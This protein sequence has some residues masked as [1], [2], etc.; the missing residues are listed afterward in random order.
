MEAI[1]TDIFDWKAVDDMRLLMITWGALISGITL[2]IYIPLIYQ[3]LRAKDAG[4]RAANRKAQL[5]VILLLAGPVMTISFLSQLWFPDIEMLV[6]F[7]SFSYRAFAM[8]G[9]WKYALL[10]F[11]EKMSILVRDGEA[12]Y[13]GTLQQYSP[14]KIW[15]QLPC[16]C[17]WIFRAPWMKPTI[18]SVSDFTSLHW[19]VIQL[20]AVAPFIGAIRLVFLQFDL[21]ELDVVDRVANGILIGSVLSASYAINVICCVGER[22][23]PIQYQLQRRDWFKFGHKKMHNELLEE[24][25]QIEPLK[26]KRNYIIFCC[27][28]PIVCRF[29]AI[30]LDGAPRFGVPCL[31]CVW[32]YHK[33]T[34]KQDGSNICY[35]NG[36]GIGSRDFEVMVH[37]CM[38][39]N[40]EL[41][42]AIFAKYVAF[43][44]K[45]NNP[46]VEQIERMTATYLEMEEWPQYM[47][48]PL[49][50]NLKS[51]IEI[52]EDRLKENNDALFGQEPSP[53]WKEVFG[54]GESA[55]RKAREADW[56]GGKPGGASRLIV[57]RP[58]LMGMMKMGAV[59]SGDWNSS[60]KISQRQSAKASC[61]E[62][63]DV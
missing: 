55:E 18:I 51:L 5:Q 40:W 4:G 58:S 10:Q 61:P 53:E 28:I 39:I 56:S 60:P 57:R 59:E 48:K 31:I 42:A 21:S 33:A 26:K 37:A 54:V 16:C 11:G 50:E 9:L 34:D 45:Y 46:G 3:R 12:R 20:L 44:Q 14:A 19:L 23:M 15:K 29:L 41:I 2:M 36:L 52:R 38:G 1:W 49:L 47:L 13:P 24:T 6:T 35:A 8:W 63:I 32:K 43:P 22:S 30:V 25:P 7:I 27:V 17:V 62:N